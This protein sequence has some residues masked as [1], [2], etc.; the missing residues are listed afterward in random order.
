MINTILSFLKYDFF[1]YALITGVAIAV[2]AALLGVS[3]VLKRFSMIGDGLSHVGFGASA[4][5]LSLGL[6]PLYVTIPTVL[7]AALIL[8]KFGKHQHLKGDAVIA[9]V[10]CS[11]LAIGYTAIKLANGVSIDINSYMFGS[12]YTVELRD[13][14]IT[15][16]VSTVIILLYVIFYNKIFSVTFDED[17]A[18]SLGIK[19]TRYT[20]LLSCLTAVT[21]VIGMKMMGALLISG[22]II[23]PVLSAIKICKS[24]KSVIISSAC[25]ALFNFLAGVV[26]SL[27]INSSP[28]ASVIIVSLV[29]FTLCSILG[30]VLKK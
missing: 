14:L 9:L 8:L 30:K 1:I 28:G 15:L 27:I 3:L 13:M 22:L 21:V 4:I 7:V 2:C 16:A 20:T 11:S 29:S 23:F 25:I 10:S 24:Y 12:I 17:F 5:A 19:A 6:A 26:F 18:N